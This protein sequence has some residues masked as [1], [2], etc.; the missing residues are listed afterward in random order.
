MEPRHELN[1]LLDDAKA[2]LRGWIDSN[3]H[4]PGIT[5]LE[6][7]AYFGDRLA[8]YADAVANEAYLAGA[9]RGSER[10]VEPEL[11]VEIDGMRWK[12]V[13]SLEASGSDDPHFVAS[14]REDGATVVQFGDGE[15]GRRP[16]TG[17]DIRVKYRR[18]S[19][20]VSVEMQ[21]GRVLIDTDWNAQPSG[22]ACGIYRA[23][24]VESTDPAGKGRLLVQVPAVTGTEGHWALPCFPP[25]VSAQLP[26]AGDGVW[27]LFEQGNVQQPVWLGRI[28][29]P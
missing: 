8:Y 24:V 16:P 4:D 27:V 6:V 22:H 7:L 1:R 12:R 28:S 29:A 19:R 26:A 18:R 5:L 25:D 3:A 15:H 21:Q 13:G 17:G 10:H 2:E 23:L 11:Q 20:F 9:R 14:R